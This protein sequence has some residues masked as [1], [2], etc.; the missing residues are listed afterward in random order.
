MLDLCHCTQSVSHTPGVI[1]GLGQ[2]LPFRPRPLDPEFIWTLTQ[3][4]PGLD[5]DSPMCL[6]SVVYCL[7]C[8]VDYQ[9]CVVLIT[10]LST[11]VMTRLKLN[12]HYLENHQ[13]V[14]KNFSHLTF[15]IWIITHPNLDKLFR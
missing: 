5:R 2:P 6:G 11:V 8:S 9:K 1:P 3:R 7:C 15:F 4:R 10:R 12:H 14:R 13:D